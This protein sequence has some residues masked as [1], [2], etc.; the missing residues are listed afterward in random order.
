MVSCCDHNHEGEENKNIILEILGILCFVT[1]LFFKGKIVADILY[2]LSY[3]LIGYK[4]LFNAIKKIFT[5]DIF[6]ENFLMSIATIGAMLIHEYVEAISVLLLYKVGEYLQDKA[7]DN[8][9][10]KIKEETNLKVLSANLIKG[11][12][13][14]T[15]KPENLKI[16]DIIL[17]RTGES[18][19]VDAILIDDEATIDNSG[20]TGESKPQIAK[21]NDKIL[22]SSVNIG[23]SIKLRVD[24]I[25]KDSTVSK[26]IEMI[27][28]A[29]LKKSKVERFITKFSK[30][31]TPIIVVFAIVIIVV[32][33]IVFNISFLDALY[34]A[35]NFLVISCPC[36]LVISV[37]LSF[38]VGIGLFSKNHILI[39]GT[40]YID[41]L[42]NL[43]TVIFD[44]TGTI[45]DGNF[46][47][48]NIVIL[49]N[50]YSEKEL[51]RYLAMIESLSTHFIAKTIVKYYEEK[52]NKKIEN[53]EIKSHE[54]IPGKGIIANV[55][56]IN[57]IIGNNRLLNDNDIK[58]ENIDERENI[59]FIA[60]NKNIAG[61]VILADNIK[62][63]CENIVL[64]LKKCGIKKVCMLTGDRKIYTD[65]INSKLKFDEVKSELLPQDKAIYIENL[66]KQ[67]L[68]NIAFIGDGINDSV[69]LSMADIGIAMSN[70]S[71]I[72]IK[73]AD[74]ILLNNNPNILE[75][76][77]KMAKYT[78]FIAKQNII[79]IL[80][81]KVVLL[82][83]STIGMMSMWIA[84]FGDVGVTLICIL[85]S[86]RIYG[87]KVRE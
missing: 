3:F 52:Y 49:D 58:Y 15:V 69:A 55:E 2:Y 19:P 48:N 75:K 65:T 60:I 4:I 7:S 54:E 62:N 78:T 71:D 33:P 66:K 47:V 1:A 77:V 36:A 74:V 23:K 22:S 6:D 63:G 18:I 21:L 80:I 50:K 24:S 17:V 57:F 42:A 76:A 44:K 26:I 64:N 73:S 10:R 46:K 8:T 43:N 67:K 5:K 41:I 87:Y 11:E 40:N 9:K 39:K 68:G 37:P 86:F 29:T 51:L 13:I 56:N 81:I 72:A 53:L 85:N 70:S 84:I 27:E 34:R 45:T 38:F 31:Y 25:Y 35:L 83:L 28:N 20:L 61:Y 82:I 12:T 79:L 30:I 32:L 14:K 59:L 16:G